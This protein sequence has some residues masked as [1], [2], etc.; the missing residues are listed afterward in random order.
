MY[1]SRLDATAAATLATA[2]TDNGNVQAVTTTG[3]DADDVTAAIA[4]ATAGPIADAITN[5][6][7]SDLAEA[8]AASAAELARLTT[9]A[10]NTFE[11]IA[12]N[13]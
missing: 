4:A 8:K 2:T 13:A 11:W 1:F 6:G 7:A 12:S 5:S 9:V 3:V 10:A